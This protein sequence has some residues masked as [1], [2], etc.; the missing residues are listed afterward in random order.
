MKFWCTAA[1][2]R[3]R[4]FVFGMVEDWRGR[5]LF[6]SFL[7]SPRN[8]IAVCVPTSQV[9][10]AL[11]QV[12]IRSQHWSY[13]W[14][15]FGPTLDPPLVPHGTPYDPHPLLN[16]RFRHSTLSG[17]SL[18]RGKRA[19]ERRRRARGLILALCVLQSLSVQRGERLRRMAGRKRGA[20]E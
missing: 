8:W 2:A 14:S 1:A 15:H 9:P 10:K 12:K 6:P 4:K 5:G 17:S 18:R 7:P 11:A 13:L 20:D 19:W 3:G 16:V